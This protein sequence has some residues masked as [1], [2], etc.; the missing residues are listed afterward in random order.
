MALPVDCRLS[1]HSQGAADSRVSLVGPKK[2]MGKT[3]DRIHL[4]TEVVFRIDHKRTSKSKHAWLVGI[5]KLSS[6]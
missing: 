5:R 2:D 6:D 3:Q 4:G 1:W